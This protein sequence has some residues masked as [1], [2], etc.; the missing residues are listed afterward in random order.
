MSSALA[1]AAVTAVL[2]DLLNDGMIDHDLASHLGAVKVTALP[3]D[4]LL[5]GGTEE[6]QLNLFMYRV[7]NN[8]GWQNACMPSRNSDGEL[9]QNQP[10]ALNLH[11][12]LS[13]Y[14]TKDF[15]AEILLGYGMQLLHEHP[16]LTRAQINTAL[17]LPS[18]VAGASLLP[19]PFDTLFASDLADQ[20]ERIKITPDFLGTEE[21]SKLWSATQAHL[22]PSAAYEASVVLIERRRA[23]RSAPPVRSSGIY[24][25]PLRPPV[26]ERAVSEAGAGAAII[27]SSTL[28]VE[29]RGLRGDTT[30]LLIDGGPIEPVTVTD[31]LITCT[32]GGVLAGL[33]GVQVAHGRMMGDPLAEHRGVESN[34]AAFAVQPQIASPT[35]SNVRGASDALSAD[36]NIGVRPSVGKTQRVVL[37]LNEAGVPATRA[38]PAHSYAFEDPS[39]DRTGEPGERPAIIVPVEGVAAGTY[40]VRVEVDGAVSTLDIDSSGAYVGPTVVIR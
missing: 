33:H 15:H 38:T 7:S 6:N 31:E 10:L 29:G 13:A 18:A 27:H 30:R 37:L 3:P 34:A 21:L 35:P 28:H 9:V 4:R 22:R 17:A 36:V 2:T 24:A 23:A 19:K 40:L 25:V 32:L 39:R 8:A 14:G 12:L 16:L 11:Y 5:T 26:I 1:I 20:V